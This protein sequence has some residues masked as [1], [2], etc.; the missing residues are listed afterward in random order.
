MLLL[1]LPLRLWR[2]RS[3]HSTIQKHTQPTPS[4][5]VHATSFGRRSTKSEV[6]NET[7]WAPEPKKTLH[8]KA[9]AVLPSRNEAERYLLRGI[10]EILDMEHLSDLNWVIAAFSA[11][12]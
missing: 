10:S 6:K 1:P 8:E 5:T 12:Y 2:R 3:S 9:S 7:A 4:T 11:L